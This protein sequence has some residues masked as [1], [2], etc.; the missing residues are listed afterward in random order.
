[1]LRS[2]QYTEKSYLDY[3]MKSDAFY[4]KE[5]DIVKSFVEK[6]GRKNIQ[7]G[8]CPVCKRGIGNQFYSKWDVD[9]VRCDECKTVYALCDN[10]TLL[11]YRENL[12]LQKFRL[13]EDYQNQI[14]EKREHI[15]EEFL[16]WIFVRS[17]RF[18]RR[19]EGLNIIDVGNRF[20]GYSKCIE[21]S[22]LCGVYDLRDSI[23]RGKMELIKDG[24][25][26]IVLYL[27]Q[28]QNEINPSEKIV[29]FK[30]YL[31]DD[32]LLI[33][34]TRAG[35][36]FDIITLKDKNDKIYPYEH[37]MLPSVKGLVCMLEENGYEV[38]EITTPGV[39]D[40]KYVLDNKDE[41]LDADIF[42]KYLMEESN[43]STLQEFQRFLQKSQMSSFV[44]V[45]ARKV[46]K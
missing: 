7:I 37:I 28:M 26:D 46:K 15:W 20:N 17:F 38:I 32:G 10:K 41:L 3:K 34:N 6:H 33:L 11:D 16:D 19:C 40:V 24:D 45:I 14:T 4:N 18:M 8:K 43:Q 23:L 29:E 22:K 36:G 1:M 44:C 27:D 39:M 35:S 25:A 31:K 13:S 2:F 5:I 21:N 9:Y 30:K 42:V 12:E